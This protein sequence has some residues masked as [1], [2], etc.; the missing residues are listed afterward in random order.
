MCMTPMRLDYSKRLNSSQ[1]KNL[2]EAELWE[3]FPRVNETEQSLILKEQGRRKFLNGKITVKEIMTNPELFLKYIEKKEQDQ[4]SIGNSL[5][6]STF[7]EDSLSFFSGFNYGFQKK[8]TRLVKN[9]SFN[10][11]RNFAL[12]D[13]KEG[14]DDFWNSRARSGTHT[15]YTTDNVETFDVVELYSP[16]TL[17]ILIDEENDREEAELEV[18]QALENLENL[19]DRKLYE[20]PRAGL[21]S[22]EELEV[23]YVKAGNRFPKKVLKVKKDDVNNFN[24]FDMMGV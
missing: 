4:N 1:L 6:S 24:L 9:G 18:L 5:K 20:T 3:L 23:E 17:D 7:V 2:T 15:I 14:F 16:S 8:G 19:V 10:K 12:K 22:K 11:V 21:F 13:D